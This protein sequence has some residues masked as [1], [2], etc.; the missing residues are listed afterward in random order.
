MKLFI[1]Y[2][3]FSFVINVYECVRCTCCLRWTPMRTN[4]KN[5]AFNVYL[6]DRTNSIAM[7][8]LL[9]AIC[10]FIIASNYICHLPL[11]W[12]VKF[13][14][15][16]YFWPVYWE[17]INSAWLRRFIYS[18]LV[19]TW[20]DSTIDLVNIPP[21]SL[22]MCFLRFLLLSSSFV[23]LVFHIVLVIKS[24]FNRP[25]RRKW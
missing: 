4:D 3:R 17:H 22:E 24:P 20:L 5:R 7:T 25:E 21:V 11:A 9:L 6:F 1:L 18:P 13:R 10:Y 16:L 8:F 15:R 14:I 23:H 2:F 19:S 12:S